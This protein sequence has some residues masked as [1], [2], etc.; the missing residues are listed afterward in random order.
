MGVETKIQPS[1]QL[2]FSDE[3]LSEP[4]DRNEDGECGLTACIS[5]EDNG[6]LK[7]LD[8]STSS[9]DRELSSCG[10]MKDQMS[11]HTKNNLS[12]GNVHLD[13]HNHDKNKVHNDK[14]ISGF[15]ESLA[16]VDVTDSLETEA[17]NGRDFDKIK[18]V[19]N[20]MLYL[21]HQIIQILKKQAS[22]IL[23]LWQMMNR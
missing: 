5:G 15:S 16:T 20:F 4:V 9:A 7:P 3:T 11:C 23:Y 1:R 18:L 6:D 12:G 2:N 13:H 10:E 8:M 19:V 22:L 17:T 21:I 14:K